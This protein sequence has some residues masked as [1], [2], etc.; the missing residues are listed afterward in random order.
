MKNAIVLLLVCIAMGAYAQNV[1]KPAK[2]KKPKKEVS[3][4][5]AAMPCAAI[6]VDLDKGTINGL[7]PNAKMETVKRK[8]PCYTGYSEEDTTINC[9]GGVFYLNNDFY[10]YTG[11]N[12]IEIRGKYT[13][14]INYSLLGKSRGEVKAT[15]GNTAITRNNERIWLYKR[16]YGTLRVTFDMNGRVI[17][18][19]IYSAPPDKVYICE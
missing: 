16:T 13:G 5:N 1:E 14:G 19:G 10:F 15:L 6:D 11:N 8:L 3:K 12:F 9:G 7:K 18:L 4:V 2:P 17:E